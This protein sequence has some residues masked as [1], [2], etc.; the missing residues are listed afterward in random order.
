MDLEKTRQEIDQIDRELV[1]LLERRMDCVG[2]VVSYKKAHAMPVLDT[3][4]EAL[5]FQKVAETVQNKAYEAT[6]VA[7]FSD[8]LKESRNYQNKA[9]KS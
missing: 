5:I 9:L 7:T 8:I 2:E 1:R 6:I 4:R 3:G